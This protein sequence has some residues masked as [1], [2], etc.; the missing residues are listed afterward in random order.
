MTKPEESATV[1]E[2]TILRGNCVEIMAS[3]EESSFDAIV[4]DP[5]Y[6][7][8]S[9]SRRG[10]P[11][12][13]DPE[14]PFGR[15]GLGSDRGGF[16]GKTWDGTGVAFQV[17][18]WREALRVLKPGGHLLAF[19]GTRTH[20]RLM[21][22][23]EDAGFEIRDTFLELGGQ[24]QMLA[25]NYGSG[26]PKSLDVA[27]SI[28]KAAKGHPQ[29]STGGDPDSPNSGKFRTQATEGKRS[30]ADTGQ[31]FGAGPGQY[32]REQGQKYER[33]LVEQAKPWQGWGT[34]LKP[35]WEPIILC[36]KPL[37]E[38]N[39]AAN[40]LKH[41]TGG[42]NIDGS[43]IG[44]EKVG[45]GGGGSHL[46]EGGLNREGGLARPA[47]GRWPANVL[48]SHSDGCELVGEKRVKGNPGGTPQPVK[49]SKGF[50]GGSFGNPE[51]LRPDGHEK[52]DAIKPNHADADGLETVDDWRCVEGCA[53]R[54]LDEQ[55]RVRTSGYAK[56]LNR[57]KN[58]TRNTYAKFE[59]GSE[60]DA[61]Y[62][63]TG[64]VSR[65][66]YCAKTSTKERGE[67]N[68]HPTVKPL[69][70]MR[71]LVRLVTPPGGIVL[72][73]FAG[74]GSTLLAARAEGFRSVGIER[75][76]EYAEIA[77]RRLG[78]IVS[79][80]AGNA[81]TVAKVSAPRTVDDDILAWGMEE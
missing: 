17:E 21:C 53:V 41:G 67:G 54:L 42:L 23:L 47:T 65:F 18:T 27:R 61:T 78:I 77:A 39:V 22:A 48:L 64:G 10:S 60:V 26:F 59:G 36:R 9:V 62:G 68:T 46:Y 55:A 72:D 70:L 44:C 43:R 66:F 35:A 81:E 28:D 20:H 8:T 57:H 14:I 29:G 6:D 73:P 49:T 56:V 32:M 76:R 31:Q 69:A 50:S 75:E 13:N 5:P 1:P 37:S 12:Q 45:W 63:D 38:K 11:R 3:M 30:E 79:S 7:L 34:A 2:A 51:A 80:D 58:K 40:V 16:M 33:D 15:I 19:G 71:Y 52:S 4:C 25:W 74:S 24:V